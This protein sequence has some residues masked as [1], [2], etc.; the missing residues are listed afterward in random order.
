LIECIRAFFD[1]QL[2]FFRRNISR[3]P[4]LPDSHIQF[5]TA[6]DGMTIA[7]VDIANAIPAGHTAL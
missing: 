3:R 6:S 5:D 7:N 1:Y 4:R 2:K